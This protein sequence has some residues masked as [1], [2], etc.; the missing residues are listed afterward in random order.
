MSVAEDLYELA[1][2]QPLELPEDVAVV[3]ILQRGTQIVWLTSV[4]KV[5]MLV[6]LGEIVQRNTQ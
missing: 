3:M 5:D 4:P 2:R 6:M 1:K